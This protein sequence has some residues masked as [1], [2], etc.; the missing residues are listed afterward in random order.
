MDSSFISNRNI[1]YSLESWFFL[2]CLLERVR[3]K[4]KK[5]NK[6]KR[7]GY[8]Q[9]ILSVAKWIKSSRVFSKLPSCRWRTN[10]HWQPE[11][12]LEKWTEPKVC[13]HPKKAKLESLVGTGQGKG[14]ELPAKGVSSGPWNTKERKFFPLSCP[15][16]SLGSNEI[17]VP[18]S[19]S[20]H[21]ST[22]ALG[23]SISHPKDNKTKPLP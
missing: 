19:Q 7:L 15:P 20:A 2:S 4:K 17:L 6:E 18:K 1:P 13:L 12:P 9:I 21:S 22:A 5:N 14:L 23:G 16:P 8:M 11:A 3:I 10:D